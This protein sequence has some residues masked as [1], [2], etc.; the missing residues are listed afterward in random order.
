MFPVNYVSRAA[1]CGHVGE[2]QLNG[3]CESLFQILCLLHLRS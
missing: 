2:Q 1:D 3:V